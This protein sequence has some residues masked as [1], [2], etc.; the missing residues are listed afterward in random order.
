MIQ[1]QEKQRK[2]GEEICL[3]ACSS[4][5]TMRHRKAKDSGLINK[6]FMDK[7]FC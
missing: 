7:A 2:Q 1:S 4:K 6:G 3:L 5:L